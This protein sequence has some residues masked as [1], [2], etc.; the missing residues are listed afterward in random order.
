MK[1]VFQGNDELFSKEKNEKEEINI[2]RNFDTICAT[3][4]SD[5]QKESHIENYIFNEK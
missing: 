5:I 2:Y 4:T 1:N 3:K